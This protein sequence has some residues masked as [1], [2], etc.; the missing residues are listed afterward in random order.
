MVSLSFVGYDTVHFFSTVRKRR[1]ITHPVS[2]R[3]SHK[4]LIN[5]LVSSA[6][7]D[8]FPLCVVVQ[9]CSLFFDVSVQV[10][11]VK[12][13]MLTL[14]NVSKQYLESDW[15][16]YRGRTL[17]C[18][19]Q[20]VILVKVTDI[21]E[22]YPLFLLYHSRNIVYL[23]SFRNLYPFTNSW[24]NLTKLDLTVVC[25]CAKLKTNTG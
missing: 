23:I 14:R 4:N 16:T 15:T 17:T 6:N 7:L 3:S 9:S 22:F 13:I 1:V 24:Y 11:H 8:V 2:G 12:Y 19:C 10:C 20:S 5:T 25:Q 18:P 21:S